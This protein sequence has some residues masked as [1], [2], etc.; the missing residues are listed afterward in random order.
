MASVK[1]IERDLKFFKRSQNLSPQIRGTK[2]FFADDD[3][4]GVEGESA[5]S[6]SET[7]NK[8]IMNVVEKRSKKHV[9][10]EHAR[11]LF[12]KKSRMFVKGASTS[13]RPDDNYF[14]SEVELQSD[15]KEEE[16][17]EAE[18]TQTEGDLSL[19]RKNTIQPL[20]TL[21]TQTSRSGPIT[22]NDLST[23][24]SMGSQEHSGFLFR[25]HSRLI[26]VWNTII[27]LSII[28]DLV[29][30]P[31]EVSLQDVEYFGRFS[32]TVITLIQPIDF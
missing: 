9:Q 14:D 1:K 5:S 22:N 2:P 6:D 21:Y 24:K 19:S 31:L 16:D 8:N 20:K 29:L 17:E 23:Q 18:V 15:S 25:K 30:I 11:K 10:V 3:S 12:K 32:F 7:N 4:S 27:L 13:L 28:A 26:F